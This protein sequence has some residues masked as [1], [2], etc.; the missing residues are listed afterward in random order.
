MVDIGEE[1]GGGGTFWNSG[2]F[3]LL[4]FIN[5]EEEISKHRYMK[6]KQKEEE[7]RDHN[8]VADGLAGPV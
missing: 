8:I 2:C 4:H 5:A 7:T 1:E 6:K 3:E